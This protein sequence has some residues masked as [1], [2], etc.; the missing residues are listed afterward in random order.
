M[1]AGRREMLD[2]ETVIEYVEDLK[3]T[4]YQGAL[5]ERTA[6]IKSFVK[7][8]QVTEDHA[9]LRYSPPLPPNSPKE[10]FA[11]LS[12]VPDGGPEGI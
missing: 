4:L 2:L 8:I 9:L 3:T 11:V 7:E 5:A 12:I 10:D 1:R 6:L